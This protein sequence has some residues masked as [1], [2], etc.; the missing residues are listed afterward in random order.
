MLWFSGQLLA[1]N[2]TITGR[3]TDPNGNPI[4]GATI[5]ITGTTVRTVAAGNGNFSINVPAN[6][7]TLTVT[8]VGYTEQVV[9]IGSA[10]EFN[11]ALPIAASSLQTVVVST[12]YRNVERS[13]YAG[14]A[15]KVSE[16]EIRNVPIGSFEQIL[17]GRA[18]GLTV[19]SGSGQPGAAANVIL[20]GPTSIEGG[21]SPL[22]I[23]DGIPVE[24]AV[25]QSINPN[26]I[27]S[28]DVLKDASA[29]AMYGS[30]GAAGVI[31]VN[32]K[33]GKSG[34]M[35]LGYATQYGRKFKPEF[36]YTPMTTDQLLAAQE[37]L[38]NVLPNSTLS[39]WGSYATLPGW[40]YSP[41]N[42]TKQ[43]NGAYVPKTAADIA[44][45]NSFLDSLRRIRTNWEDE[46]YQDGTFSN[47]EISL[48]GGEGRTRIYS[49][50]GYYKEEGILKPTDMRRITLRTN[51]DYKDEK[52]S[53]SLSSIVGFTRRTLQTEDL[54]G[55]NSFIN[56]FGVAQ[57]TP[58]YVT[59]RLPNGRFNSGESFA[60]FAPTML[61]KRNYDKVYNNQ[62]KVTISASLN[63][64]FTKNIYAGLVAG[65]DFRETQNSTYRDPRPFN[66]SGQSGL[67]VRTASG[68]MIESLARFLQPNVK[69]YAG[70]RNTFRED[71]S[72]EATVYGEV[73]NTYQKTISAQGFGIDTLRPNT[74]AAV[75]TG[76]ASNQLFQVVGGAKSQRSLQSIMGVLNYSFQQKYSVTATYRYDG[77]SSL[78]EANRYHGFYSVGA[79][80]DIK[81]ES[82]MQNVGFANAL[83]LKLS[84][85]QSANVDNFP[86][87]DFG[88]IES[89][90]TKS[91]TFSG[92]NNG[93]EVLTPGNP[94]GDWEF[95]N[96]ANIGVEFAFLRNRLYGDIQVYDKRTKNLFASLSLSATSGFTSQN[97]NA[98]EMYNRGIEYSLNYD[99]V[100]GKNF[101]WT[102]SANGA[103]NKNK[104]T[105]LGPV[106]SYEQGTEL[107]TVGLPLGSHYEVKWAGVDAATG[108][109]LYYTKDGKITTQY[110]TDD[111]V[112]E[113]GTWIPPVTGGFGTS[114]RFKNFEASAFF[115]YAAKTKRVNNMEYFMQNPSFLQQGLNQD[116]GYT[117]WSKPGDVASIQSPLYQMNFSSR[118]I[119]DASWMRLRNAQLSYT[120][121]Q[122]ILGKVKHISEARVYVL[123][124]NLIT[125]TKWRGL[126]PEDSNNISG[127]EYPNPR[128]I[129]VGLDIRF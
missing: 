77:V 47:N 72:F 67:S 41:N 122:N 58:Q 26:D 66:T 24:P 48:S 99:V 61:E 35:R 55:F 30:R 100:A 64:D 59:Q 7:R 126:D 90:D 39:E 98:G 27:A 125:W 89:Y 101:V 40:Q 73:I 116:A 112:Q 88:Y 46:F 71:H 45:G 106:N 103:Y 10:S 6:A 85:G 53:L 95:T 69:A 11:V 31:V 84:Y 92:N 12:G 78:P 74:L 36:G 121:P 42:P 128:A 127:T 33:R 17:Q 107:V 113:Y 16:K 96:T 94:A 4:P 109:P 104:V 54:N 60:L 38:G 2:R 68:S 81:R 29:A 86:F 75:T 119:Q 129:T 21:S 111:R 9:P 110:S 57:L 18:P 120:V 13:K 37:R 97:V 79:I 114:L 123:G 5:T 52:L 34:K 87:G 63:Y 1:Q 28:I 105:S 25:F 83:R 51:A 15:S 3:I 22:Y 56:P 117:F 118:L 80:W 115:N 91:A 23:V 44:F 93:I 49:N 8:S 20:R 102:V 70:Y 65:T 32:T 76:N 124:Q 14:A 19:L 50:L 62:A 108:S 43:V 82:F